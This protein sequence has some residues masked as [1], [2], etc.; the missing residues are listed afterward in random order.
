[1][2]LC[3]SASMRCFS[4]FG[5]RPKRTAVIRRKQ[6]RLFGL[7]FLNLPEA[8]NVKISIM[9]MEL[10]ITRHANRQ[11]LLKTAL[12][13]PI[14][15]NPHNST[16]FILQALFVLDILLDA[17]A[18]E[19]LPMM[20]RKVLLFLDFKSECSGMSQSFLKTFLPCSLHRHGHHNESLMPHLHRLC[21]VTPFHLALMHIQK[22]FYQSRS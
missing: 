16:G 9:S 5:M 11:T 19:T 8:N 6:K 18:E 21:R 10:T 3:I 2:A 4:R 1:M 22:K 12:L 17:P 13:T 15:I 7:V 20:T 14:A